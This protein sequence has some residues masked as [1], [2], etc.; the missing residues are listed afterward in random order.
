MF[1]VELQTIWTNWK[2]ETV[3]ALSFKNIILFLF[4]LIVGVFVPECIFVYKKK[5]RNC[6]NLSAKKIEF[7]YFEFVIP[8]DEWTSSSMTIVACLLFFLEN[9]IQNKNG[10]CKKRN[11]IKWP[12]NETVFPVCDTSDTLWN[13]SK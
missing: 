2:R 8:R 10:K 9:W 6:C 5:E 4:V 11:L 3:N 7:V 12:A 13:N 1:T